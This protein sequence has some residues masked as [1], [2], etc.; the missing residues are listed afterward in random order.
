MSIP[1]LCL[2][3]CRMPSSQAALP[4]TISANVATDLVE[5]TA[6]EQ[7]QATATAT[8]VLLTPSAETPLPGS[9]TPLPTETPTPQIH[10]VQAGETL[11]IIADKFGTTP[12]MI[13]RV[14]EIIDGNAI[15]MGQA[16]EIPSETALVDASAL[17]RGILHNQILCPPADQEIDLEGGTMIGHS[18][19]CQLPILSYQLGE[20]ETALVLVG[21]MHGGY[22]WNSIL[23]AYAFLDYLQQNPDVIP[24]SLSLTV[25]PNANPD[26]L[27]AVTQQNGRF[28]ADDVAANSVP[29]RF[30]GNFVD[31]NRNWDC[32]WTPNAT[33]QDNLVSGG[34]A[35][36]S[37]LEN[38]SLRDFLLTADPAAVLFLHS[39]AGA[40]Y[41]SGC[42][43]IDPASQVLANVYSQA[44]GYPQNDGFQHYNI[45][46]DASN[47]LAMQGI[48]AITVELTTHETI[49][50]RMNLAGLNALI[51]H[52]ES[53]ETKQP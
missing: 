33:W 6:P 17:D 49:D 29:G 10:V 16:L 18:A 43:Q 30:N 2:A 39:A 42:G 45:T 7:P 48:P 36:F 4:A 53:Q 50:W 12:E 1:A 25:I 37:E 22:E 26:G 23:L 31:L 19:V 13:Q 35:P 20:G 14:N 34:A 40:V 5:P 27:Y 3:A 8:A 38:Q 51:N 41:A 32:E 52:L 21:G 24:N 15:Y 9:P 46:G 11:T 28:T 47:W 44:S